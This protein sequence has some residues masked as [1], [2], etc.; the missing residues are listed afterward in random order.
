MVYALLLAHLLGDYVFQF[1]AIARWKNRS[2]IGVLVHGGIVTLCTLVCVALF[3]AAWWPYAILI[4]AIHTVI[5]LVRSHLMPRG[6]TTGWDLVLY[7][8]DQT[9]HLLTIVGVLWG[10]GQ[11]SLRMV[12]EFGRQ[13]RDP[14]WMASVTA[15]CLLTWPSWVL[16]RFVVRGFWGPDAAPPLPQRGDRY[17]PMLE[18][19]LIATA[20]LIGQ[21]MLVPLVLIPRPLTT[22]LSDADGVLTVK[23]QEHWAEVLLSILLAVDVGF[24]LRSIWR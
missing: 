13:L 18:R 9:L 17:G 4:G 12:A 21:P 11:V 7:L 16:V 6:L 5:D 14:R 23:P 19:V 22:W 10:S 8:A 24:V 3:D 15:Y 20:V 2:V 1:D